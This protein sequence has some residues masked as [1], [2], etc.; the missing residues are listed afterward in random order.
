MDCSEEV[1]VCVCVWDALSLL[2][3]GLLSAHALPT[4]FL[5]LFIL[6]WTRTS[7]AEEIGR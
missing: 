2:S 5:F 3:L 7:F 1:C 6:A 4:A